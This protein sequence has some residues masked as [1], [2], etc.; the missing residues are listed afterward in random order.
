M[1]LIDIH[2]VAAA[3]K[4]KPGW[5]V[6]VAEDFRPYIQIIVDSRAEASTD[7]ITGTRV[8]WRGAKHYL[9]PH[10]CRQ[11]VVGTIFGAIEAAELHEMREWFRYR[12]RSIYNPHMDPDQ[13]HKMM[14]TQ[15]LGAMSVRANAMTMDEARPTPISKDQSE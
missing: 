8:G 5:T 14:A 10:M 1:E 4:Y 7:V 3:I 11:E 9:S 2:G 12:G 6:R 13:L 15:G